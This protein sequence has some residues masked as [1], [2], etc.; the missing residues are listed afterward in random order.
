MVF[1]FL[2]KLLKIGCFQFNQARKRKQER[3]LT[4]TSGHLVTVLYA[5]QTSVKV[6]LTLKPMV[7]LIISQDQ[8]VAFL[9]AR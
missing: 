7:E 2:N 9:Y 3:Q 5:F 6:S 4:T 1:Y 8:K